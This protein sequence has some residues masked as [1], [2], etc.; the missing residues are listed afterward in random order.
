MEGLLKTAITHN[1][2]LYAA[3]GQPRS[4][5]NLILYYPLGEN[6]IM[7]ICETLSDHVLSMERASLIVGIGFDLQDIR[8]FARSLS[9]GGDAYVQRIFTESEIE[10]CRSLPDAN[11]SFAVRFAAKEAAIKAL[12]IAGKEGL[13]WHDFEITNNG[14][15][16]PSMTLS[17]IAATSASEKKVDCLLVSLTHSRVTAGAIVIAEVNDSRQ[18]R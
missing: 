8:D 9:R 3:N 4:L 5:E 10:Y 18:R 2:P 6:R 1:L 15:G 14:N 12:M 17:G 16:A 11:P 13:S 7:L